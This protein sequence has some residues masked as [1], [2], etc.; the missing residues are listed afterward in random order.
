MRALG[1]A[2]ILANVLYFAWTQWLASDTAPPPQS[3]PPA[4]VPTLVLAREATGPASEPGPAPESPQ[5]LAEASAP[6]SE[7]ASTP[8]PSAADSAELLSGVARCVSLGPFRD[9]TEA[10]QGS[11]ALRASGHDPRTRAAEGE[12]WAGLWVYLAGLPSRAE[13]QRAMTLLKQRGI[14]DAY[15]MPTADRGADISLGIF[16]DP[17][18]AQKRADEVRALGFT[19]TTADHSRTGRVYWID[20]D[21]KPTDGFINPAD[22][23]TEAGKITRLEIKACPSMDP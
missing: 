10:M 20:V 13:A 12:V 7:T 11:T 19:P 23:P 1:L 8:L 21:L 3:A 4:D 5:Q 16:S 9:L 22:I 15:V 2:L 17:S 14:T 18:R 6:P